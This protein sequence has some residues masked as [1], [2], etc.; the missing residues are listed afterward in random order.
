MACCNF[1]GQPER[2]FTSKMMK[3]RITSWRRSM[4]LLVSVTFF[5]Q[6]CHKTAVPESRRLLRILKRNRRPHLPSPVK[7]AIHSDF[8]VAIFAPNIPR[9]KRENLRNP[10]QH[11]KVL[12]LTLQTLALYQDRWLQ[13]GPNDKICLPVHFRCPTSHVL[14]D[15]QLTVLSYKAP[16]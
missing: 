7:V 5:D 11:R 13:L 6:N 14:S 8:S 4:R 9:V 10:C 1:P 15:I 16:A 2:W 12:G 3:H